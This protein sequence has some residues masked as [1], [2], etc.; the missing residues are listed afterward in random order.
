MATSANS[1]N[2]YG[3]RTVS[4]KYTQFTT[5]AII[6]L[7]PNS[8]FTVYDDKIVWRSEEQGRPTEEQ[9]L[10]EEQKIIA[11]FE[12]KSYQRKRAREY[13][14]IA[15]YLDAVV[16]NDQEALQAYIDAC[17]AVKA[18]YPKPE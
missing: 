17:N 14:P 5:D 4:R 2:T 9:I 15:E 16:K 7:A 13:P 8:S 10:A 6:R 1:L 11:E 12:A 3:D 18:K